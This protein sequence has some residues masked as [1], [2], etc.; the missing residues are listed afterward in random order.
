MATGT[1]EVPAVYSRLPPRGKERERRESRVRSPA[2]PAF[3]RRRVGSA[4]PSRRTA[5]LGAISASVMPATD[6]GLAHRKAVIEAVEEGTGREIH[7]RAAKEYWSRLEGLGLLER[8]AEAAASAAEADTPD[9]KVFYLKMRA[10]HLRYVAEFVE[11]GNGSTP[12]LR[13]EDA[14]TTAALAAAV[15]AACSA[16]EEACRMA[17]K[18]LPAAHPVRLGTAFNTAIFQYEVLQKPDLAAHTAQSATDLAEA[19]VKLGIVVS[20]EAIYMMQ[21]LRDTLALWEAHDE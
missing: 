8:A 2:S 3:D 19:E 5:A 12:L 18:S 21:L 15:D 17:E 13:S 20:P 11:A 16:Y 6:R 1:A 10:D 9:S 4:S 14:G 7:A